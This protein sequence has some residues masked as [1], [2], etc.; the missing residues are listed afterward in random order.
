MPWASVPGVPL[1]RHSLGV[2]TLSTPGAAA[3][4]VASSLPR[5]PIAKCPSAFM[6]RGISPKCWTQSLSML[7]LLS[8]AYCGDC[9][10]SPR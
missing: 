4:R 6:P 8:F 3:S 2:L 1:N 5:L 10:K 7:L 9:M